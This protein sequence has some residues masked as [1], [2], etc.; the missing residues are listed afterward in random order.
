MFYYGI[1]ED[2]QDPEKRGRVK[3]RIFNLHIYDKNVLPTEDLPWSYIS[4]PTTESNFSNSS[5]SIPEQGTMVMGIFMDSN[6]QK[7]II[8][9]VIPV[10]YEELPDF[11][12]G[13]T[14]KDGLNPNE[15]NKNDLPDFETEETQEK[16]FDTE[17]DFDFTSTYP[18]KRFLYR[19]DNGNKFYIDK[20]EGNNVLR[21]QHFSG[22]EIQIMNDG[23]IV[24]KAK[25]DLYMSS[26]GKVNVNSSGDTKVLSEG[27]TEVESTGVVNVSSEGDINITGTT[28]NLN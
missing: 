21:I 20:T 26:L 14:D 23:S 8:T 15:E 25:G 27:K 13:F 7:F 1:I 24:L 10:S 6:Y 4:K 5:F 22:T 18:K 2:N 17:P 11:T 3:V 28:I 19:D 9:G 16:D 12:K